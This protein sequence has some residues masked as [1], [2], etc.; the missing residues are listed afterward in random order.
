MT[1]QRVRTLTLVAAALIAASCS[2]RGQTAANGP[3]DGPLRSVIDGKRPAF[4]IADGAAGRRAWQDEQQFYQRSEYRLVWSDGVRVGPE[5]DGLIRAVAAADREGLDPSAYRAAELEGARRADITPERAAELDLLATYAFMRYAGDLSSST[6]ATLD[7]RVEQGPEIDLAA[8]LQS[9]LAE[10]SVERSI[11]A[12]LPKASQYQGLK[13]QLAQA[14]ARKDERTVQRIAANMRRWRTLPADLGQRYVLVNIPAF[15][16]DVIEDGTSVLGMK[17]VTGKKSSPTPQLADEMTSIVF[18]P[19]WHIPKA[20]VEKEIL[21]KLESD[22]GY[23][24]RHNIVAAGGRYRQLPGKGNALGGV[25][26][27]FPN[28]F[29]V[30]LHDTPSQALFNR[31]ER[32]FSHGCVRLDE[33]EALAAYLLRDQP[34]WTAEKIR[35]SMASGVEHTVTLTEPLPI[36]IVYFTAWEDNGALKTY[37][38]VYGLDRRPEKQR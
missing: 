13:Q 37:P 10:R 29:N 5:L 21:P 23:L 6:R 27:Q 22:P 25:K 33:P 3:T 32:D 12:L 19:S 7:A 36:Y 24:E 15:R 28:D 26:F 31:V 18:S 17:V 2:V 20:I 8:M 34:E 14:R 9:A 38:D 11:L 1:A 30:Y 16:L 4:V 35:K